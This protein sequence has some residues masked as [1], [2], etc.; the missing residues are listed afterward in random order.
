MPSA[1]ANIS[2][3]F[4]AQI[5]IGETRR[6]EEEQPRGGD[7]PDD[8]Q[9]QRQARGHQRTEGEHE[10]R[11]RHRPGDELGL[12]HRV[13]VRLVEVR[14][15]PRGAG[16]VDGNPGGGDAGKPR[17]QALSGVDHFVR[18]GGR[19]GPDHGR[20]A[21]GRDR[22]ARPRRRDPADG[23]IAPQHSLRAEHR[24]SELRR[25]RRVV[26]RVD[27]DLERVGARAGEVPIDLLSSL[28]GLGA[29]RLPPGAG[30]GRL[31][32]RGE[33]AEAHCD[34]RPGE[35]YPPAML[36]SQPSEPTDRA[37]VARRVCVCCRHRL[38][39][40]VSTIVRT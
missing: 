26:P 13:A 30:E 29:A 31:D 36:R 40:I 2:A 28:D 25:R 3:K 23:G 35:E 19:P 9:H 14:P 24:L 33:D 6:S 21:V 15:H 11:H 20:M 37:E 10:D 1:S 39:P 7:Q 38:P 34:Q 32:P 5:E 22:D 4:I 17:L 16:Q 12:E 18:I 8:G 27:R